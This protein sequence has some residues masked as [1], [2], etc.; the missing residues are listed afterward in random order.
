MNAPD[1]VVLTE[2]ERRLLS[3][4]RIDRL[5]ILDAASL[6]QPQFD[7][8]DRGLLEPGPEGVAGYRLTEAGLR[9][10]APF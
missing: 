4:F 9:A 2:D 5:F 6:A 7:L 8:A 1:P 10:I 3:N